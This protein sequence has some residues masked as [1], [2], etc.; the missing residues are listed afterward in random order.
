MIEINS[1]SAGTDVIVTNVFVGSTVAPTF[2]MLPVG[3]SVMLPA[4]TVARASPETGA[5]GGAA[6]AGRAASNAN[7]LAET[8]VTARP[9]RE[10]I[11]TPKWSRTVGERNL[12]NVI[13]ESHASAV[14]CYRFE[15]VLVNFSHTVVTSPNKCCDPYH[16]NVIMD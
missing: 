16:T 12:A 3:H 6:A 4:C 7:A 9:A 13:E 10:V 14:D 11:D 15:S 5:S 1:T 8:A 2:T